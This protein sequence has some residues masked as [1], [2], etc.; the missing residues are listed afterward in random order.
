MKK[1]M[2][3]ATLLITTSAFAQMSRPIYPQVMNFGNSV[4]V[5]IYNP[6]QKMHHCSGFV[7]I[8]LI[9]MGTESQYFS[10]YIRP[11]SSFT[12]TIWLRTMGARVSHAYHSIFCREN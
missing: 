9:P 2:I 1:L 8:N 5:Q 4:Q 3:A 10:E 12:R 6:N 11:N 7:N